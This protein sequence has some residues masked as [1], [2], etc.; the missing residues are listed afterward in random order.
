MGYLLLYLP[1][2]NRALW[3]SAGNA[4]HLAAGDI[5]GHQ[6]AAAAAAAVGAALAASPIAGSLYI[7]VGSL[8]RA[9]AARRALVGRPPAAPPHRGRRRDRLRRPARPLLACSGPVPRL[10]TA[11]P[12]PPAPPGQSRAAVAPGRHSRRG[13]ALPRALRTSGVRSAPGGSHVDREEIRLFGGRRTNCT[14]IAYSCIRQPRLSAA[15]PGPGS[16]QRVQQHPPAMRRRGT[17]G[18]RPFRPRLRLVTPA[19]R[20]GWKR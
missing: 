13:R 8:R 5:A 7:A 4:G 15:S 1:A 2:A 16:S 6:Y 3:H 20:T 19:G 14:T 9:V 18:R 10:V 17:Y 11:W 12:G